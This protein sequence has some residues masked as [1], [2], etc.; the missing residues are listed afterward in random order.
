FFTT[1]PVG[2]GTGLGL[3]VCHGIVDALGGS[4]DIDSVP[5]A[6]TSVRVILPLAGDGAPATAAPATNGDVQRGRILVIDDEPLLLA[7]VCRIIEPRHHVTAVSSGAAALE[8]LHGGE[9]FDVILC[10]LMMPEMNGVELYALVSAHEPELC[11]RI[12]FMTGGAVTD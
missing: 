3:Y 5:G 4:I 6:W 12:V 2:V 7:A 10:D 11:R 1:K 9:R 8:L